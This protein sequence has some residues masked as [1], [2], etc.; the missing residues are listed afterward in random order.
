MTAKVTLDKAGRIVL[1]KFLRDELR[2]GDGDTLELETDGDRI[3]LSPVRPKAMLAKE[4]GIWVYQ[5]APAGHV[6]IPDLIDEERE[7]RLRE[8]VG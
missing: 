7:K 2:L 8:L 5:G 3:T 4:Y 6:S 1:P